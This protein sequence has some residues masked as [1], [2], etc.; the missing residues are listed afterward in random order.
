MGS[1]CQGLYSS[2]P[3]KSLS[4][5][6]GCIEDVLINQLDYVRRSLFPASSVLN[7]CALSASIQ[8]PREAYNSYED[9]CLTLWLSSAH[10]GKNKAKKST[11]AREIFQLWTLSGDGVGIVDIRCLSKFVGA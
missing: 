4:T 8:S 2:L 9:T 11:Q 3:S 10:S 6:Q 5:V 7:K 1:A